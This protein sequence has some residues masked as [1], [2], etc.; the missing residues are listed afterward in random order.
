MSI[1]ELYESGIQKK[2]IAHFAAMT[3]IALID[4]KI[5]EQE[6]EVLVKFADRL[7]ISDALFKK[8]IENPE[9]Y[10]INPPCTKN[11]RLE[12]LFDLFKVVF[13]DHDID[14]AEIKL[15]RRY[16]IGLGCSDDIVK[17][18]IGKS[19]KIFSG[20]IEFEDYEYLINKKD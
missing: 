7:N 19:I 9:G 8:I 6:H 10:E 4:G 2:N 5:N 1:S 18:V 3:N 16:A 15:I 20:D 12:H 14:E 11:E 13:A 17:D